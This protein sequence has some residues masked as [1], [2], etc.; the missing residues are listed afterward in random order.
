MKV[1]T[2]EKKTGNL[3]TMPIHPHFLAVFR[4]RSKHF[5]TNILLKLEAQWAEPCHSG[6]LIQNLPYM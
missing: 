5:M 4:P 6:N 1:V 2:D 3:C